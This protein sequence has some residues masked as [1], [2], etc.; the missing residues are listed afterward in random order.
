MICKLSNNLGKYFAFI[1]LSF[2]ILVLFTEIPVNGDETKKEPIIIFSD[3]NLFL[4]DLEG[5]YTTC[6]TEAEPCPACVPFFLSPDGQYVSYAIHS[7]YSRQKI[8]R[9][10]IGSLENRSF[11][12]I[13]NLPPE[14][15]VFVG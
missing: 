4:T 3:G 6:L 15:S 13:K 12:I 7:R 10:F 8:G 1:I 9:I 5:S 14:T 2:A 11:K